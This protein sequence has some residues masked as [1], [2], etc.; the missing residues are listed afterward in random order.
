MNSKNEK[1]WTLNCS[2]NHIFI[3][4]LCNWG[5][6]LL[7]MTVMPAIQIISAT[8]VYDKVS[9]H[10]ARLVARK[11]YKWSI[12]SSKNLCCISARHIWSHPH[13]IS[14]SFNVWWLKTGRDVCAKAEWCSLSKWVLTN[15]VC[16]CVLPRSGISAR[17]MDHLRLLRFAARC[18]NWCDTSVSD[19]SRGEEGKMKGDHALWR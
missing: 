18:F 10:N 3:H 16:T 5:W 14:A 17:I 19:Q 7:Y 2:S 9:E 12:S 15:L 11:R 4:E 13:L 1:E 6:R 8:C